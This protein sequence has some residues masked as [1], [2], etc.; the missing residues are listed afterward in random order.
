MLLIEDDPQAAELMRAQ[1]DSAGY[2]VDVA[3]D[4]ETGLAAARAHAAGRDRAR[5]RRCP[6][7]TA[8]R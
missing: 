2:R 1:L 5:R 3:G 8:G 7:S 4:G 6:A